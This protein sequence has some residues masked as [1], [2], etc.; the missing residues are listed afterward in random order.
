MSAAEPSPYAS[1]W[2]DGTEAPAFGM[3]Y[4]MASVRR[5]TTARHRVDVLEH[6]RLGRALA[7]DGVLQ[8]V[9][10]D[11]AHREMLVHVPVLGGARRPSRALVVGE[12]ATMVA[13]LL[14]HDFVTA[15]AVSVDDPALLEISAAVFGVARAVRDPR[16]SVRQRAAG[17]ALADFGGAQFE[18]VVV[19]A[20]EL[21]R[22]APAGS[23]LAADL[24]DAV[25]ACLAPGGVI[26]DCDLALLARTGPGWY[27]DAPG[28]G[29]SLR[30]AVA[31]RGVLSSV[32]RYFT[33]SPLAL[34]GLL[35]FF[36]YSRDAGSR[37]EPRRD[38]D[39]T[40]Y[41]TDLHR[42][43]FALPSFWSELP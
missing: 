21:R 15:V 29:P 4:D 41:N 42:A 10:Q 3:A 2:H 18:V 5:E 12:D 39:G 22:P 25:A 30:A 20:A 16:V 19:A 17:E 40:H 43:A 7:V 23:T 6:P 11:A 9:E 14:K 1:W 27:R 37:A 26:A 36:L 28:A 13:E 32:E 31:Q 33:T 24:H 34:G 8:G 35:G 38:F